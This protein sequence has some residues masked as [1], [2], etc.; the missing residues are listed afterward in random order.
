[1]Q[2]LFRN[3]GEYS[4]AIKSILSPFFE[5][6]ASP[7][8]EKHP[9]I[10]E[11]L[12]SDSDPEDPGPA[13]DPSPAATRRHGSESYESPDVEIISSTHPRP[14]PSIIIHGISRE[15][16]DSWIERYFRKCEIHTWEFDYRNAVAMVH[17]RNEKHA[18]KAFTVARKKQA[19]FR[20]AFCRDS[21]H[22][23]W[24]VMAA[25]GSGPV[26]ARL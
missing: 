8:I 16:D 12:D 11:I 3:V 24:S 19:S 2:L 26:S 25:R 17:F 14:T 4:A 6:A 20:Y 1:M 13:F 10:I 23:H 5:P 15:Q 18:R 22:P 9:S 21:N 7:T